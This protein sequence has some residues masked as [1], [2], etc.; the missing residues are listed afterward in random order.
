MIEGINFLLSALS[1][2]YLRYAVLMIGS[3]DPF[4]KGFNSC[5]TVIPKKKHVYRNYVDGPKKLY[6]PYT[7]GISAS[8][9]QPPQ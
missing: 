1:S 6:V 2:R 9:K 8:D 4:H 7:Y 5:S 3:V